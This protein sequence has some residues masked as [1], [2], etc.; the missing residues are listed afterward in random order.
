[1]ALVEDVL[2]ISKIEAGKVKIEYEPLNP[3]SIIEQTL[4]IVKPAANNKKLQ[5]VNQTAPDL[6][7]QVM[8]D[9]VRLNQVLL[10]L[11]GDAG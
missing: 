4:R 9:P 6:P 10:N 5:L 11:L 7:T 2:N 1:M 8:G 3:Q